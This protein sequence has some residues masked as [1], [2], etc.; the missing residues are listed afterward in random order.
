MAAKKR[1][2]FGVNYVTRNKMNQIILM[3]SN[4]C[5]TAFCTILWVSEFSINRCL[6]LMEGRCL[7]YPGAS[8]VGSQPLSLI[9]R[10]SRVARVTHSLP[11]PSDIPCARS[12]SW[13][14]NPLSIST[15][16]RECTIFSE[17]RNLWN[18]H[19][20]AMSQVQNGKMWGIFSWLCRKLAKFLMW[21]SC[22]LNSSRQSRH[23][24]LCYWSPF[25][26]TI[27]IREVACV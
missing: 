2:T 9:H 25:K 16:Q 5:A 6:A 17:V 24:Y 8:T 18:A 10:R 22:F 23:L 13:R 3:W 11:S 4:F 7:G 12:C 1:L 15:N 27:R 21:K 20:H 19:S 14:Q 26:L